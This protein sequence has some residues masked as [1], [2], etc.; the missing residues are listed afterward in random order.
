MSRIAST[1]SGVIDVRLAA[2]LQRVQ[3]DLELEPAPFAGGQPQA[4]EIEAVRACRHGPSR[5]AAAAGPAQASARSASSRLSTLPVALRGS[6]SRKTTSRGTLKRARLALTC[7]LDVALGERR[8]RR[9]ARRRPAAAGR[10][11]RPS[12]PIAATSVDAVE[13]GDRVLDLAREDVLAARDDHLVVAAVDEQAPLLVEVADVAGGHEAVDDRLAAAAGVAVEDELVAD[14]D[15]ARLARRR[16]PRRRR[17]RGARPCR[18]AG[19]RRCPAR[20]AG[21]RAWRSSPTRPRSSRR[22]CRGRRRTCP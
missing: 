8:A 18:A 19:G 15:A 4:A 6:S 3:A 17:R 12:T 5:L 10:S 20:R 9:C 11:A 14:E 21:R 2:E 13:R 7:V 16:P 22:G 1:A